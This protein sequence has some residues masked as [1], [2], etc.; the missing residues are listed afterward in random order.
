[1]STFLIKVLSKNNSFLVK[2]INFVSL[3]FLFL[4]FFILINSL[5]KNIY[6]YDLNVF[7]IAPLSVSLKYRK[8]KKV[9]GEYNFPIGP[10]IK[11][12]WLTLPIR[13]YENP[14]LYR[15][16][17][18]QE[19]RKRSII[20]QWINLI[21]GKTYIGSSQ[22]GSARLLSYWSPSFLK[23]NS[24]IY[25]NLNYYGIHNFAL[26]ILEDLGPAYS[27]SKEEI[28]KREQIYLDKLFN[29]SLS[30]TLN[31]AP[32]AGVLTGYKFKQKPEFGLN[33]LAELNPMYNKPKSK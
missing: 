20:Y 6:L 2:L 24:P 32:T 8:R 28:F 13:T 30:E 7:S 12:K 15:N 1:M 26:A 19:N 3:T 5:F 33:R 4:S 21:T 9:V 16:L 23:R 14:N 11:P 25:L 22:T 27:I 10:H 31:L 29:E 18:G 17:I